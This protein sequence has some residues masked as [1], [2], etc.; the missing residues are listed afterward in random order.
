MFAAHMF[1]SCLDFS[2]TL[3]RFGVDS[4]LQSTLVIAAGLLIARAVRSKGA[5]VQSAVYR[6]SLATALACPFVA[7]LLAAVE[8]PTLRLNLHIL[9]AQSRAAASEASAAT[10]RTQAPEASLAVLSPRNVRPNVPEPADRRV[11][12][13]AATPSTAAPATADV[14]AGRQLA[15]IPNA[16]K[17][18]SSPSW[19][20]LAVCGLAAAWLLGTCLLSIRL[21]LGYRLAASLRQTASP[22]DGCTTSLCLTLAER[23]GVRAPHV[24]RTP[25]ASSPLLLGVF[26]PA[27]LL[28]EQSGDVPSREILVHELAHLTRRDPA[29][30]ALGRIGTALWFFQPL[31]WLLVR[32]MVVA[33]EEVCDDYVLHLGSNRPD[34]ARQLVDIAQQYCSA[35]AIGVG[36]ISPRSWVGRR[37]VRILDPSRQLST[38]TSRRS[39]AVAVAAFLAATTLVGL[40][41]VGRQ[42]AIAAPAKTSTTSD[43]SSATPQSNPPSQDARQIT[44]RGKVLSPEGQPVANATVRAAVDHWAMLDSIVSHDGKLPVPETKT[45]ANGQFTISFTTQPYGDLSALNRRW[46]DIW[47]WTNI[48]ASAPGYGAAWVTYRDIQPDRPITLQLVPDVPVKG[49]VVDAAGKPVAGLDIA[50]AKDNVE[51]AKDENLTPWLAGIKEGQLP[52]VVVNLSPREIEPALIGVPKQVTTDAEGRFEIRGVGRERHFDLRFKSESASYRIIGV[53]TR[54]MQPIERVIL[55]S[56]Y[57]RSEPAK[58]PLFGA[59]FTVTATPSRPIV[60]VVRDAK[61]KK[62]LAG[63]SVESDK[64][65]DYPFVSH[66]V[67]KTTTDA[68][69]RYRL[70]GMP[71]GKDNR[72]VIVPNDDQPYLMREVKVPDTEGLGP[73]TV[74]VEL[75]RGVWITGRVTEKTTGRPVRARLYYLPFRSNASAKA[76][77]EFGDNFNADGYQGRYESRGDGSYRLVGLPGRAIVGAECDLREYRVGVGADAI[78]DPLKEKHF[79]TYANPIHPGPSWPHVMKEINLPADAQSATV[80]LEVDPGQSMRVTMVDPDG[81]PI[82]GVDVDGAASSHHGVQTIDEPTFEVM[83]LAPGETRR[84]VFRDD[85]RKLGLVTQIKADD[86]RPQPIVIQLQPA[87]T[88]K[89]RLLSPDGTPAAG[90]SVEAIVL[91]SGDF[92]QELPGVTT[93]SQGRFQYMLLPGANYSLRVQGGTM[94]VKLIDQVDFVEG[95]LSVKPN[96]VKDLGDVTLGLRAEPKPKK[97]AEPEKPK[98]LAAPAID[99]KAAAAEAIRLYDTN[100]DGKL[101]GAE[102]DKCPGLKAALDEVDPSGTGEI[103]AEMI[104]ARIKAWQDSKLARMTLACRVTRN[105]KPL[106]GANVAFVPEKFLGPNVKTATGKTDHNGL[107]MLSIPTQPGPQHFDPPGVAPGFYRVEITKDGEPVPAKYNSDTPF[108]QEVARDAKGIRDMKGIKF[109]LKY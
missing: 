58:E 40:V 50:V 46:R 41:G 53:V 1:P 98:R 30:N 84:L 49:R 31:M 13:P 12:S 68:E 20:S 82:G 15:A 6:A 54:L 10:I 93:D 95:D 100:N 94:R 75:H 18:A 36:V 77:P 106:V 70:V 37:V 44:V 21:L 17:T 59:E 108:G 85:K 27:I 9:P 78:H 69:G 35:P 83:N 51:A 14:D 8:A 65:A 5:A 45:D 88:L 101:S 57:E 107:A 48:A 11:P 3:I 67:L 4:F 29:W 63:V 7:L 71:K 99:A 102:L 81:K 22:A 89:G 74:D 103:T 79:D 33:A 38:R 86:P 19:R 66:R 62:P 61:T 42:Q 87:G 43:D 26:R 109:D 105:G 2:E 56:G 24:L 97:P 80:D 96:Q 28:P 55:S 72:L 76:T 90:T 23:L 16:P 73:I 92:G 60:G 64:L 25:F 91:P 47:K 34:Y 104:A 32:R 52:W 39:V